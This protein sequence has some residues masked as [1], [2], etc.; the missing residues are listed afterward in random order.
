MHLL[1][2]MKVKIL[3]GLIAVTSNHDVGVSHPKKN[4]S[5]LCHIRT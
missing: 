1:L 4:A 3:S 5:I 2:D